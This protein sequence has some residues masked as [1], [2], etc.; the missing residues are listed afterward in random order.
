MTATARSSERVSTVSPETM[1]AVVLTGPRQH[2]IRDNVPVPSPGSFEVLCKVDSVA[3]CGTDLHIYEGRFPGRW[4]RS[5]PFIPGHEWSGTVA[6][7]GPGTADLG[8]AV[9]TQVA[10]T[11]H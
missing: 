6:Q 9:G 7:L 3:I 10:G 4:P 1:R 8:W 2:Q 5:Y 11:S